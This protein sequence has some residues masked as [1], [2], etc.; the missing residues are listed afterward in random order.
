[1]TA[2]FVYDGAMNGVVFLAYVL[3]R[4]LLPR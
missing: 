2:P 4:Y 1:M 3:N